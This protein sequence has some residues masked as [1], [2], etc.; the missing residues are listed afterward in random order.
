V[1]LDLSH[2]LIHQSAGGASALDVTSRLPTLV[3]RPIEVTSS[4]FGDAGPVQGALLQAAR[5]AQNRI[6]GPELEPHAQVSLSR[7]P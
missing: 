5:L 6:F 2:F 3:L 1:A 7:N 4:H